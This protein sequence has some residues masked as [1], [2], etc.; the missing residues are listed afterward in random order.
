MPRDLVTQTVRTSVTET[1]TTK[2]PC[3][4]PGPFPPPVIKKW[5]DGN[6]VSTHSLLREF[7]A[8]AEYFQAVCDQEVERDRDTE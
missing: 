4:E 3:D 7:T 8:W 5:I 1:V 2:Y 6:T